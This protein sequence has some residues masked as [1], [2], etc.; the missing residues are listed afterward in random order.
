M[1]VGITRRYIVWFLFN[2]R[3]FVGQVF[4]N[5][6]FYKFAMFAE[7]WLDA[8]AFFFPIMGI[9]GQ[10]LGAKAVF[11]AENLYRHCVL[12]DAGQR[13]NKTASISPATSLKH[14][15]A[16]E[17][18]SWA[19]RVGGQKKFFTLAACRRAVGLLLNKDEVKIPFSGLPMDM[20][21]EAQA[22]LVMHLA[23]RSRINS[24]S[25]LRFLCY[26]QSSIMDW[27]ETQVQAGQC[28]RCL[29]FFEVVID[30]YFWNI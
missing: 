15:A 28:L 17:A 21:V 6:V 1:L 9:R 3:S 19:A 25:S 24:G 18:F 13:L 27:E 12:P 20:W 2:Q 8:G 5:V 22:K 16:R 14:K 26:R 30:S 11:I 4:F 7:N 23:Q 10:S 29:R